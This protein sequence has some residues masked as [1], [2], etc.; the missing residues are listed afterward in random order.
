[1]IPLPPLLTVA[2]QGA[3]SLQ[4]ILIQLALAAGLLLAA[5]ALM[6][7]E[8][9]L[10]S[11]GILTVA[12]VGCAS[13]AIFFAFQTGAVAG[14]I[15]VVATPVLGVA[16]V[17]WGI[18]RIQESKYVPQAEIAGDAGYHHFAEGVQVAEGSY[19]TLVT[20]A[21]PTGRA[22]FPG[23]E[24]DVM[25]RGGIL[26]KGKAVVV[27]RIEGPIV[28]VRSAPPPDQNQS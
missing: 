1:V 7:L 28:F 12:A 17:T 20:H 10:V 18:K 23:G 2:A 13:V 24:I 16:V 8:F 25:V 14:W 27:T 5:L 6:V 11:A 21:R 15:F 22:R 9:Y 3:T 26:D 4:D 19:G